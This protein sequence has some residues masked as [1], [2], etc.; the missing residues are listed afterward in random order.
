MKKILRLFVALLTCASL[1]VACHDTPEEV[2]VTPEQPTPEEPA[3]E[4]PTPDDP[5]PVVEQQANTF[6]FNDG[7]EVA[8]GSLLITEKDGS[9]KA[10]FAPQAGLADAEAFENADAVTEIVFP[11]SAIGTEINLTALPE[12]NDSIYVLSRLP[13]FGEE[14]GFLI[15]GDAVT[16]SDGTLTTSLENDELTVKCEFTTLDTNVKCSIYL[17]GKLQRIETPELEGSSIDYVVK[18]SDI[19]VSGELKTGFYDKHN[20]NDGY[21]FTY[22]LSR[23]DHFNQVG[24]NTFVQIV[25]DSPK[26]LNGKPFDVATTDYPFSFKLEYLDIA[27]SNTVPVEISN[28]NRSG[29]SGSI[30]LTRNKN[31]LYDVVFDLT[32]NNGDVTVKGYYADALKPANALFESG[33]GTIAE[34]RSAALYVDATPCTLYLSSKEGTAG[35]DQYDVMCEVPMNEWRFGKFMAFSGQGSSVTW[36]GGFRYSKYTT[37]T[38]V[39]GGNWRVMAPVSIGDGKYLAECMA[40]LFGNPSCSAYY[41]GEIT[42]IE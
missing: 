7:D 19:S 42:L 12:D 22:S 8:V 18:K 24:N 35:P 30:T 10:M 4:E 15:S 37:N 39:S 5:D 28:D 29:A 34:I 40:L 20:W 3:P 9:V 17:L 41:Y 32:L 2:P 26:L 16:V 23:L 1:T 36:V 25:V 27:Q 31:G 13:E 6:I 38:G 21:T 33:K 14:Y 11:A